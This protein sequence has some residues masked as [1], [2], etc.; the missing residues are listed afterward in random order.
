[1]RVGSLSETSSSNFF[2]SYKH[3]HHFNHGT[4]EMPDRVA[5]D[6]KAKI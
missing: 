6:G 2:A 3:I 4:V 5:K 1:M